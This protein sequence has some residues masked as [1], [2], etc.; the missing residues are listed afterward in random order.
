MGAGRRN[1]RS[2]FLRGQDPAFLLDSGL[3]SRHTNGGEDKDTF[4]YDIK[5]T[6]FTDRYV[7]FHAVC[8][9]DVN[10]DKASNFA[11]G[12]LVSQTS[13]GYNI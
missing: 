6:P 11:D 9:V 5:P 7:S 3:N 8:V 10:A 13:S 1:A 12:N 4:S 2:A